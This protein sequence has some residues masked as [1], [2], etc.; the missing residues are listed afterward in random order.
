MMGS[1]V[2][3]AGLLAIG[4]FAFWQLAKARYTPETLPVHYAARPLMTDNEREFFARL[5]TALPGMTI[6]PQVAMSSVVTTAPS[7]PTKSIRSV[8]NTFDRKVIDFVVM[9]D[10]GRV[11]AVIELDDRTH[12]R[13]RDEARDAIVGAAGLV[14][15]RYASRA[16]PSPEEIAR[17]FR[18]VVMVGRR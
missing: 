3:L 9:D 7:V 4:V 6:C 16:K 1:V 10:A 8:R 17:D 2:I 12:S 14:T 5:R 18:D 15:M 11:V 13:A